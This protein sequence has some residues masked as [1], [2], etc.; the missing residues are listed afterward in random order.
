MSCSSYPLSLIIFQNIFFACDLKPLGFTY[1][2][3]LEFQFD[4]VFHQINTKLMI[5]VECNVLHQVDGIVNEL[6]NF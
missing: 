6:K 2:Q 3:F 4:L 1:F 5:F